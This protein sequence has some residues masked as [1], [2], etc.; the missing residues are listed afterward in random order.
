VIPPITLSKKIIEEIKEATRAL[1]KELEVVGLMNI[2]FAIK[3]DEL[4]VLEVNP[5]ASRTIPFVSKATGVPLARLATWVMMGKSLKEF[6]FTKEVEPKHVAVKEAVFPFRRFPKVDVLLGPEMKSTGEVMGIDVD[7]GLAYAKA[8]LAAGMRLPTEGLVFIS[9]KDPDKPLVVDIA[10]KL[11]AL[12]FELLATEGT[13]NFLQ[14][15]GVRA[16]VIPKISEKA[17]PNAV[18][19]LKNGEIALVINTA[20]GKESRKDAYLIRRYAMELDVPYATTL[21]CARAMVQAIERLKEARFTVRP[22]QDYYRR[23]PECYYARK[24][25]V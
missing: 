6:G 25:S 18:D 24:G 21:S 16:K 1:A 20:E 4:F 7:F 22:L 14:K 8:Q 9:V 12:G 5:R 10:K 15:E 3:D 19:R 2:Q 23:L 11:S 13:A 17:R